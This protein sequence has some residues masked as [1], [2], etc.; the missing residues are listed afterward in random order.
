MQ[1]RPSGKKLYA[2]SMVK[3]GKTKDVTMDESATVIEVEEQ[4]SIEELPSPVREALRESGQTAR[5]AKSS[6]CKRKTKRSPA[7]RS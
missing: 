3:A 6:R 5:L 2:V 4:I 1:P 7:K